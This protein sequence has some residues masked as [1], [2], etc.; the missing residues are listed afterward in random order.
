MRRLLVTKF[1]ARENKKINHPHDRKKKKK[2][3][4]HSRQFKLLWVLVGPQQCDLNF[5]DIFS[6]MSSRFFKKSILEKK[7]EQSDGQGTT[8]HDNWMRVEK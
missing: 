1:P 2:N 4:I 3:K 6:L 8:K 5:Y 7:I